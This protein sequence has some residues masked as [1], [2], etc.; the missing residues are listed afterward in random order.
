MGPE[1]PLPLLAPAARRVVPRLPSRLRVNRPLPA[2]VG[3]APPVAGGSGDAGNSVA[4][5]TGEQAHFLQDGA[6]EV[7]CRGDDRT[8]VAVYEGLRACDAATAG[9]IHVVLHHRHA[10]AG[11]RADGTE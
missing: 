8:D 7:R 10:A 1:L 2:P 9:G 6:G 4:V 5:A 3:E 11:D